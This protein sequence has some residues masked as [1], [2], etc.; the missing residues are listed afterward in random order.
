MASIQANLAIYFIRQLRNRSLQNPKNISQIRIEQDKAFARIRPPKNVRFNEIAFPDFTV[1]WTNLIN[2]SSYKHPQK[3]ILYLH[4]GGYA[5]GSALCYRGLVG[6]IVSETGIKAL[7]VSYRLAPEHPFPAA[8]EDSICTY[9][10]LI[11]NQ[12]Y[13]PKDIIMMGDSAGGGLT[14]STLLKIKELGLPQPLAAVVISP[15]T[16]LTLSGDSTTTHQKRDPL[17][18]SDGAKKWASWYFQETNPSHQHISPLFGDYTNIAPVLVHVGTEEILLSDSLRLVEVAKKY[19]AKIQV[20]IWEGMLHVWHLGWP[21]L[22]EARKALIQIS[23]FINNQIKS[24]DDIHGG[25]KF[26]SKNENEKTQET[27]YNSWF[28][29]GNDMIKNLWEPKK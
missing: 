22:P 6:K 3:V 21:Y 23:E 16:D 20:D 9:R 25:S 13:Q 10:W 17:L 14:L 27:T 5:V 15:W 19:N 29:L 18:Q 2:D 1:E 26:E 11:E 12:G 7:S 8:L 28:R 4:G 24:Y